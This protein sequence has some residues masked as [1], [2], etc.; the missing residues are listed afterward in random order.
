MSMKPFSVAAALTALVVIAAPSALARDLTFEE[1]VQAQE[2]IERVYYSH[3]IDTV[4][5][6]I[7]S[8]PRKVLDEKVQLYL[9]QSVALREFWGT[10]IT[11]AMLRRET[12][13]IAR[14]TAFPDR[15]GELYDALDNDPFLVQECLEAVS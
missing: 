6:F 5:P 1:R 14:E 8:V 3:Q 7:E 12:A 10:P 9:K 2:A 4:R 11:A 13:R 15:V